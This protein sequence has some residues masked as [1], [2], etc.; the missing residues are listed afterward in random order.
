MI[1]DDNRKP[2]DHNG[3]PDVAVI[4][5]TRGK[6]V[7]NIGAIAQKIERAQ[8]N[9]IIF[10]TVTCKVSNDVLTAIDLSPKFPPALRRV[11]RVNSLA[12][13]RYLVHRL[14]L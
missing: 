2:F 12:L 8:I 1:F 11:L 9:P 14:S 6:P 3:Y 10:A 7:F 5:D 4:T 13:R